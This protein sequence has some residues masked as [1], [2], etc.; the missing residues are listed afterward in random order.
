MKDYFQVNDWLSSGYTAVL[1]AALG[2]TSFSGYVDPLAF[3]LT[4]LTG[5]TIG[6]ALIMLSMFVILWLE[7]KLYARTNDRYGAMT[8]L[9]S[10]WVGE[11][12]VTGGAWWNKIPFGLGRP[13]GALN[14]ALNHRFGNDDPDRPMVT[15]AQNR[16]WLGYTI[17]PGFFQ[18][19]AD[20]MKFL[21][22]E[23]MVPQRADKWIYEIAPFIVVSSTVMILGLIP[24]SSG[25]YGANPEYSV[26]FA[27]AIFGIAPIGVFFGGWASNNKYTLLGGIRS[28]AQLT[29][30]EIPLLLSILGV[31]VMAGS[32]NFI[33]IVA[34]QTSSGSW[35]VFLMPLGA[36]LFLVSMLAETE[37]IPFDMP[38]AEAELVE[39]WWT[40]Y[41]DMRFG[42]LFM[43]EYLRVYAA[44][45]MFTHLFL[46]GW[47]VPFA[48][49]VS[50]LGGVGEF[51]VQAT[52]GIVIVLLKSWFVF[53]VVFVWARTA[54]PRIRTDQ[55]LEFGWRMLLPLAVLQVILSLVYRAF[56]FDPAGLAHIA[57]GTE[58]T[59][60][61]VG[62]TSWSL[63]EFHGIE[64]LSILP[65][66]PILTTILWLGVFLIFLNDDRPT[67][68]VEER[69]YHITTL[70][71]A[72]T[73]IP[74]TE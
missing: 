18:Q 49:Q 43:A 44:C 42:Q 24:L 35:N 55:I 74:G 12:G 73:H 37:R 30:Y 29:A 4:T 38:E 51:L 63:A 71:P 22:K 13:V 21:V 26:L 69:M 72:G 60:N 8:S 47:A 20:G 23:H 70:T 52:P 16:S 39:G 50:K 36:V 28:A 57:S 3:F 5:C 7:R 62:G 31:C 14:R 2:E 32:F 48:G 54:L 56:L 15:R 64:A 33:D 68:A 40:E 17:L 61:L 10:L 67:D 45:F 34:M 41:G 25:I 19:L 1:D 27:I 6:F 66:L 65:L 46:G 53:S 59:D 58:L 9:R 11:D